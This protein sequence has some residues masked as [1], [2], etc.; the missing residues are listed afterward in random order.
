MR[1]L[2]GLLLAMTLVVL[3]ACS[4]VRPPSSSPVSDP[5]PGPVAFIIP[6]L[7]FTGLDEGW[8]PRPKGRQ[9]EQALD[10]SGLKDL[11]AASKVSGPKVGALKATM[12][13]DPA[14]SNLLGERFEVLRSQSRG[15]QKA[16]GPPTGKVTLYSYTMNRAVDVHIQSDASQPAAGSV[17]KIVVREEGYQPPESANEVQHAVQLAAD[18]TGPGAKDLASSAILTPDPN[19]TNHRVFYVTFRQND[20]PR[21]WALVDLTVDKVLANGVFGRS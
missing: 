6:T 13:N 9:N 5:V 15:P 1:P 4:E 17:T 10:T 14:L 16:M 18:K 7:D 2:H 11:A 19:H 3:I 21:F 12:Q 8:P 20:L